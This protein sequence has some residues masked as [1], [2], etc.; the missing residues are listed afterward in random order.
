MGRTL[1]GA[2]LATAAVVGA[3]YGA[4]DAFVPVQL[5]GMSAGNT[6][7]GSHIEVDTVTSA[8]TGASLLKPMAAV[9]GA[10][11]FA[12][13]R[14]ARPTR[15]CRRASV[16]ADTTPP[17]PFNPADQF[18]VTAPI[19]YFDPLGFCKVGDEKAFRQ[20][21]VAELKHGRVAMLA[22]VGLLVQHY[23]QFPG[24]KMAPKG[25]GAAINSPGA[26]VALFLLSGVIETIN[27]N[28]DF[29][30]EPENPVSKIGD[31]G[32]P[33]QVYPENMESMKNRELNNGRAA[34]I[35]T[36]GILVAELA[37]GKDGAQQ[38]GWA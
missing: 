15:T 21:R 31:Y 12:A 14:T 17:K 26:M 6:L 1:A 8:D 27:W 11:A 23:I 10:L 9:T 2:G 5:R 24:L 35:A 18:G 29:K 32:N 36:L 30:E 28:L 37:T 16:T 13:F 20:M 22:S 7:R 4:T 34:M 38:L 3:G 19:G 25:I 33:L